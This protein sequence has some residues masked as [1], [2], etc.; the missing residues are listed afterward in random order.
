MISVMIQ[1]ILGIF[2]VL[3]LLL[4]AFVIYNYERLNIIRNSKS[5]KKKI[6]IFN[7]IYD[8]AMYH[9]TE[10][11]T[12]LENS[13]TYRDLAPSINQAGGAEYTYSFWLKINRRALIE[14]NPHSEDII[15]FMRGSKLQIPYKNDGTG[16]ANCILRK[17]KK[18]ILVKNPLIRMKNDG[19]S[20]IVE[21][22]TL[23]NP[24]AYRSDGTTLIKCDTGKWDDRNGG[25]LG[26]YNMTS[27]EYDNKW[28][29]FTVVIKEITP[30][31]DVLNKFKTSCKIYLNGVNMLDRVVEAPFNGAS[32]KSPGSAAMKHNKS[33]FYL[34]PGNLL[35]ENDS[36]HETKIFENKEL[37]PLQMSDLTYLNY[38]ANENQIKSMF[39]SG[40]SKKPF[41]LT[42]KPGV[43]YYPI[44]NVTSGT[45]HNSVKPY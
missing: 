40:F 3:I 2:V 34:N 31:N 21:Y 7:G 39:K 41:Q 22:N 9:N 35:S 44:A 38:A 26:I 37:S 27:S 24:D 28:F 13:N 16:G 4:I 30:E 11:N 25:L 18:Y 20:I 6:P 43:T 32:D 17:N 5:I 42:E 12:F 15:L 36:Y 33:P 1:A 19:T 8:Y 14:S 45:S 29:M 23:T 10:Y